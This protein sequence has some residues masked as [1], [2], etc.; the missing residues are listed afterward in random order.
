MSWLEDNT[1]DA[2]RIIDKAMKAAEDALDQ[3]DYVYAARF[4][5]RAIQHGA[6]LR[7]YLILGQS[8]VQLKSY[9]EARRA[10]QTALD[11]DPENS[12]A[13]LGLRAIKIR[14]SESE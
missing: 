5:K 14:T 9:V 12:T 3:G 2:R 6:G 10:Y 8:K 13:L 1:A 7:A 11:L 4:A